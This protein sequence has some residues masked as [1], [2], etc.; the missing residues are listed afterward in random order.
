MYGICFICFQRSFDDGGEFTPRISGGH[1]FAEADQRE[2]AWMVKHDSILGFESM[3]ITIHLK[4]LSP[5]KGSIES[6]HLSPL[7]CLSTTSHVKERANLNHP[8][9]VGHFWEVEPHNVFTICWALSLS[10]HPV[11]ALPS[12]QT[13]SL[14]CVVQDCCTSYLETHYWQPLP[15][16]SDSVVDHF[17]STKS[18]SGTF[19]DS[20]RMRICGL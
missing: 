9:L 13:T 11:V 20:F 15:P 1:S 19:P 6:I 7:R 12:Y 8:L 4:G 5:L 3:F 2:V 14:V 10:Y 17:G 16:K 18:V